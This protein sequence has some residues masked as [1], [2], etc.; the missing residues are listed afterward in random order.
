VFPLTF[1][2]ALTLCGGK[3][4]IIAWIT[5]PDAIDKL[6][7]FLGIESKTPFSAPARAPPQIKFS[8][9]GL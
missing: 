9:S 7:V 5:N 6:L 1:R 8:F 3:T 4:K 2:A